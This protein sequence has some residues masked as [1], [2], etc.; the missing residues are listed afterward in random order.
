MNHGHHGTMAHEFKSRFG[1]MMMT[2]EEWDLAKIR[3]L[4]TKERTDAPVQ[5]VMQLFKPQIPVRALGVRINERFE[6][7][8]ARINAPGL[9]SAIVWKVARAVEESRI[10]ESRIEGIYER[11]ELASNRGAY[12]VA[13]AKGAFLAAGLS[14]LE[15]EWKDA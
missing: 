7:M 10:E 9:R 14:W 4:Q 1:V 6:R 2:E 13:C 5:S 12:F 3:D 15:E 11:L 8:R